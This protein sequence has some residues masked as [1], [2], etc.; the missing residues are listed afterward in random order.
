MALL[1]SSLGSDIVTSAQVVDLDA[2][3]EVRVAGLV[4]CRQRP[5]TAK[6]VVFVSLE[7]EFGLTNVVVYSDLFDRE[8][9]LLV[10]APMLIVHG[11]IQRQNGI[12]HVVARSFEQLEAP[13][14]RLARVSHDFR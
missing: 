10:S 8:R 13:G 11:R 4:T 9:M 6:G 12:V 3:T 1:R 5:S 14:E 7:D 2:D